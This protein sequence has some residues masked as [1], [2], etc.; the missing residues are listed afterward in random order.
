[1]AYSYVVKVN[2]V[3]Q[4]NAILSTVELGYGSSPAVARFMIPVDPDTP[5]LPDHDDE[6][7][8]IVNGRSI[9][10]GV[11]KNI[12]KSLSG[13]G[14]AV[15]FI[16]YSR[17]VYQT[18]SCV[19]WESILDVQKTYGIDVSD[20]TLIQAKETVANH[21]GNYR[22]YYNMN[23]D[24]IEEYKLGTG[25]WNRSVAIGKNVLDW[26]VTVDTINKVNKLT[27][28][29]DRK[30][31][32]KNWQNITFELKEFGSPPY[33][34]YWKR[35]ATLSAFNIGEVQIQ[36]NITESEPSF[37]F[38]E[39]VAVIPSDFGETEWRDGTVEP[40]KK[41]T[42]YINPPRHWRPV[43]AEVDYTYEK[44]GDQLIPIKA[45]I[46]LTQ[47]PVV[48]LSQTETFTNGKRKGRTP[49]ED[50]DFDIVTIALPSV[51]SM[52]SCRV[53]YSYED[54]F[55]I[56]VEKGSG[57]PSRTVTDTQ[58]KPYNDK[59]EGTDDTSYILAK[60]DERAQ[61]EL[62]KVNRSTISGNIQILGDE[63]FDLK[64]T[65]SVEGEK[66]DV[67]RVTH[68]FSNG[69][70]T[71]LE[72]TNERFRVNIPP[73]QDLRSK[74]EYE[75]KVTGTKSQLNSYNTKLKQPPSIPSTAQHG[76]EAIP[77]SPFALY[78]D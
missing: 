26:A 48:H 57:L 72:L 46:T 30:K 78:G 20:Q 27:L 3:V 36:G 23:N 19:T 43:G 1:M 64:T 67:I 53:N 6:V 47:Y 21:K 65:L 49:A 18:Y 9:F 28:R 13:S 22:L 4:A 38:D 11:I 34:I 29:G 2:S 10:K 69:F 63:T 16:A 42:K 59:V 37:E 51:A 31:T 60:M 75:R 56:E 71:D 15:A 17:I 70:V 50:I 8:V 74:V 58:Y 24:T 54:E 32:K 73:Y 62:D 68:N 40:K 14:Y 77:Q 76:L 44:V 66:L 35:V 39:E 12:E 52:A 61:A 5:G 45:T 55:P 7:E 25:V 33:G 41:V